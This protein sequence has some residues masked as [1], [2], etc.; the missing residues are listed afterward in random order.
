MRYPILLALSLTA[1]WAAEPAGGGKDWPVYG[2]DPG[3]SKYS[4]LK[5][6]NRSNVT[7]LKPVWTFSTGEPIT[8]LPH[9]GK[10]PAF[11]ATPLVIGGVMYLSTP[12]GHAY[13]L[14]AATGSSPTNIC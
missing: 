8:P 6:I 11:E 1:V 14:D 7:G 10:E 9:K 13:A 3:G 12:Y 4:T 5:Q 2:G